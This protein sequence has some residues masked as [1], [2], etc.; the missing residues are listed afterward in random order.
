MDTGGIGADID[1][2]IHR[3]YLRLKH[4]AMTLGG[5]SEQLSTLGAQMAREAR[6][7]VPAEQILS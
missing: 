2:P 7:D 1:Y 6:S 5:A 4:L 3:F